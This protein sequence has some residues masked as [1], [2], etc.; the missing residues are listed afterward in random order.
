MVT[1]RAD[2]RMMCGMGRIVRGENSF[3]PSAALGVVISHRS[4]ASGPGSPEAAA[5]GLDVCA[6]LLD[7]DGWV[8]GDADLVFYGQPAH[9]SGAVRIGDP[10]A[11][12]AGDIEG[13]TAYRLEIDL[14]AVEPGVDRVVVAASSDSGA[15]G[16]L[17]EPA[18]EAFAPD[19]ESVVRYEVNGTEGGTAFVFGEFYRRAHGWK[20]RAVGQGYASG[21]EGLVT[22]YGIE[23]SDEDPPEPDPAAEEAARTAHEEPREPD[24]F[25]HPDPFARP[26]PQDRD[27]ARHGDR[28]GYAGEGRDGDRH[29]YEGRDRVGEGAPAGRE[30]RPGGGAP[31]GG[32]PEPLRVRKEPDRHPGPPPAPA[33]A[34]PPPSAPPV[35]PPPFAV[36]GQAHS[37]STP[38][39][40]PPVAPAGPDATPAPDGPVPAASTASAPGATPAPQLPAAPQ[41]PSAPG[42]DGTLPAVPPSLSPP[43][44]CPL[45]PGQPGP[46]PTPLAVPAAGTAPTAPAPEAGAALPGPRFVRPVPAGPWSY[47][48]VFEP[49]CAEGKADGVVTTP[50][51]VPAGPAVVELRTLAAAYVT[52]HELKPSNRPGRELIWQSGS[53]SG[54]RAEA[55]VPVDVPRNRPLRLR[56][57]TGDEWAVRVLPLTAVPRLEGT[58]TGS[59]P[60]TLLHTGGPGKV[61]VLF[62]GDYLDVYGYPLESAPDRAAATP[63]APAA[64]GKPDNLYTAYN[65]RWVTLRVPA[66][67]Y[68]FH[69][70]R[71]S[72]SW[73]VKY[74]PD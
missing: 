57:R 4:G 42:P 18:L 19:G 69:L 40:A 59:G 43:P 65:S 45:P 64:L 70:R 61:R 68:L 51:G 7:A 34:A 62:R 72:G 49:H 9:P 63:G 10:A 14:P 17:G 74:I 12:T 13:R 48:T 55:R 54:K 41:L 66:G 60:D 53:E 44:A 5:A 24:P 1:P 36:P 29:G 58:V 25:A 52:V 16:D 37:P 38:A 20:F 26:E 67:P 23:V 56:V 33:C 50:L 30:A 39:P 6:L 3:V 27:G 21:L 15:V 46:A 2:V 32:G 11:G 8:W 47:D 28:Y 73:R 35:A 31:P 71:A 22:D